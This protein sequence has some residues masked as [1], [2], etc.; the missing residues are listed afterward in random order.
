MKKTG[1]KFMV[2][3]V[4]LVVLA[5]PVAGVLPPQAVRERAMTMARQRGSSRFILITSFLH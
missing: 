5:E 1:A 2:V 3:L 4:V